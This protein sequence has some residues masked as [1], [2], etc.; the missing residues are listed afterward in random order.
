[1]HLDKCIYLYGCILTCT[2]ILDVRALELRGIQV[3]VKL[4]AMHLWSTLYTLWA[5]NTSEVNGHE[6]Y[7]LHLHAPDSAVHVQSTRSFER[8]DKNKNTRDPNP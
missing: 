6:L 3:C 1:M 7:E 8:K 5:F 2:C 4:N